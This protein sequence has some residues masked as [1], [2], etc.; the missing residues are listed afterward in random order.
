MEGEWISHSPFLQKTIA[1]HINVRCIIIIHKIYG[2]VKIWDYKQ[3]IYDL[4]ESIYKERRFLYEKVIK[5]S[6]VLIYA[7][8]HTS[9]KRICDQH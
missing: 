1:S 6:F 3:K 7:S 5:C 9:D 8:L 4:K 2:V